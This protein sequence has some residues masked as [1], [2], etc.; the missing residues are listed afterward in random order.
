MRSG[1]PGPWC[2]WMWR[3]GSGGGAAGT[4]AMWHWDGQDRLVVAMRRWRAWLPGWS[5]VAGGAAGA[6]GAGVAAEDKGARGRAGPGPGPRVLQQ[7]SLQRQPTRA[8]L[9]SLPTAQVSVTGETARVD[10]AAGTRRGRA[11]VPMAGRRYGG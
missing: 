4:V 10:V 1:S 5:G 9:M 8:D 11:V 2:P 6:A 3:A 7:R